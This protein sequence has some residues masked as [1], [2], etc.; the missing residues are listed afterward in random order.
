M[1]KRIVLDNKSFKAL[2]AESRINILKKLNE[3]RMTLSELSKKLMLKNPTIKEHCS[4]LLQ[5][6]LVKKI[7]DGRKWKYYEL[8]TKGK[9][10][11]APKPFE[12]TKLLIM[13]SISAI[14]FSIIILTMLQSSI[15]SNMITPTILENKLNDEIMTLETTI[16]NQDFRI[17]N[18]EQEIQNINYNFFATTIIITLIIG[19][20]T[21]WIV[22][23]IK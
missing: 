11:I 1:D 9:Q 3:R 14:I 10:I 8:T 19:I 17:N 15:T 4:M 5:A 21:G 2:S 22:G 12:E 18:I 7:D 13:I 6:E 16:Q 23:K 20:F